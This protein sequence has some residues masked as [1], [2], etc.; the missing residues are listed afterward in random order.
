MTRADRLAL[1]LSLL[2]VLAGYLVSDRVFERMAHI[3]DEM[4]YLWEAQAIAGSHL[5]LPTPPGQRSFLV[6]FVVDYHGQRFGKY[7]LGWPALLAIGIRL[8]IR[9]L[10]NPLLG[11]LGIWLT[12]RLAKRIFSEAVGLLAALLT[13]TSPF[14][15]MNTGSL[16][17]HPFGL[18]LSAAFALA[19]LE[20][21]TPLTPG[22]SHNLVRGESM[23]VNKRRWLPT[24]VAAASLGT[25]AITRPLTAVGVA[26]PFGLHG[27]YLLLRGDWPTRR[28][29]FVFGLV[30]LSLVSLHFI[31]QFAATGDPFL[32]PYTL[33]WS[34]DKIGFGPGYGHLPEGHNLEQAWLDTRYS[35]WVGYHD[36][37]GWGGYS[38]IFLPFGLLAARRNGRALLLG[39]VFP[40]L[41]V[42]YLAYWIGSS[43]FGPRYFYEGLY[44]LTLLSAAGIALLAGWPSRP[45]IPYLPYTGW[46]RLRPLVATAL[47]TLL[48]TANM[49]FYTPMRLNGLFGLYGVQRSHLDPFLTRSAQ[50]LTPA[51]IM[52]HPSYRWIEY[53]TLLELEDPYLD[54]PFIFIIS[55]GPEVDNDVAAHFPGRSVY[56]YYPYRPYTFYTFPK[57]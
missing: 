3:E 10:V 4:A 50:A 8:G 44:S 28:R 34:Y 39:L 33:W 36:L 19:W 46:L 25:L 12:Y 27:L 15:L 40:S 49:L 48:I 57:P 9:S 38:W 35:L 37:F 24:L 45:G 29:L 53:G 26:L 18:V 31:W 20:A 22:P 2:A 41:V 54:T 11:G 56:H 17:S 55:R 7:P 23:D 30:T 51:L 42:V 6:P 47:V 14:F 5:T 21:F 1:L 13:L 52:I 16:L 32:N 43:L